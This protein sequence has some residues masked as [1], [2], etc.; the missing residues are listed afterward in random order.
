MVLGD[1]TFARPKRY[2]LM[3]LTRGLDSTLT[4]FKIY[5]MKFLKVIF[6]K[7]VG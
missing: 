6:T 1:F 5:Y 3:D 7:I 4:S 2:K